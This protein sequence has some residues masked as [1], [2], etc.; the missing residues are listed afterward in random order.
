MELRLNRAPT[1]AN[2]ALFAADIIELAAEIS[3][4]HLDY[5]VESL[6][7]VD[8]LFE[9]MRRDGMTAAQMGETVF[10]FGCYIGEVFVRAMGARWVEAARTE[11]R[12][13]TPFPMVLDLGSG[14]VLDPISQAFAR[15]DNGIE[16][17]LPSFFRAIQARLGEGPPLRDAREHILPRLVPPA[18]VEGRGAGLVRRPVNGIGMYSVYCI[19]EK[20]TVSFI[21]EEMLE[22]SGIDVEALHALALSNL[23][24]RTHEALRPLVRGAL[25]ENEIKVLKTLDTYD[26]ARLLLVP[27]QLR[28]GE[29]VIA[30]VPDRDTLSLFPPVADGDRDRFVEMV[31]QTAHDPERALLDL[32]V[33]VRPSGFEIMRNAPR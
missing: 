5:S 2:A 8:D 33:V 27:S 10:L 19:D 20:E 25:D 7:A 30:H 17:H 12:D 13:L 1:T 32:P 31:R 18:F 11:M 24:A 23:A 6:Q 26:A 21:P 3:G 22:S 15:L 29:S 28:D 14:K 16:H 4:V 9:S